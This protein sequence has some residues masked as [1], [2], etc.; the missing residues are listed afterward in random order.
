MANNR[1]LIQFGKRAKVGT[2]GCG[3]FVIGF[4]LLIGLGHL[5]VCFEST[6]FDSPT[7][8]PACIGDC[9]R[10]VGYLNA[11]YLT[12]VYLENQLTYT[13]KLYAKMHRS[14]SCLLTKIYHLLAPNCDIPPNYEA[15]T[16]LF[17]VCLQSRQNPEIL[18]AA[19]S[20]ART[21]PSSS[22]CLLQATCRS[23]Q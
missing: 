16:I 6:Q 13:F 22:K 19:R 1:K 10:L 2:V 12:R 11:K 21:S 5:Y 15:L 18:R 17:F 8:T 9:L 3:F 7:S 23:I 4:K 14:V 20:Q